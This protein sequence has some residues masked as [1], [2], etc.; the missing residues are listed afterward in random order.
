[1]RKTA[2]LPAILAGM[3]LAATMTAS[4]AWT[5]PLDG[6][7]HVGKALFGRVGSQAVDVYTLTNW[8]GVEVRIMTYGAAIVSLKT[9]DRAGRL[10]DIVLGFDRLDPYLAGVPYFGASV[11]RYANRIAD[12]RFTLDGVAHQLPR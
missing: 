7:D 5:A 8:R 9:P 6:R 2:T 1:M 3:A 11:G 12:G 4:G 10:A